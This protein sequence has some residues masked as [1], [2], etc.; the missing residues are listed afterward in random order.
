MGN[1]AR[2]AWSNRWNDDKGSAGKLWG[3]LRENF[4]SLRNLFPLREISLGKK[5]YT[6]EDIKNLATDDWYFRR[7]TVNGHEY[8]TARKAGKEQSLGRFTDDLWGLIKKYSGLNE[9]KMKVDSPPSTVT[10]ENSVSYVSRVLELDLLHKS[11]QTFRG[12]HNTGYC[13]FVGEGR[14]C[15]YWVMDGEPPQLKRMRKLFGSGIYKR[16]AGGGGS[17]YWVMKAVG[18]TCRDCS[19]FID[20]K[21]ISFIKERLLLSEKK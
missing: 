20:E 11:I 17:K 2:R 3:K 4:I 1:V 12:G 8:V 16:M 13:L 9:E 18:F 7:K 14:Y 5:Q 10:R 21:M 6:E 15:N 19:A